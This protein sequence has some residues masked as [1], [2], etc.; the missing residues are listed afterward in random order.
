MVDVLVS[1]KTCPHPPVITAGGSDG[2]P[3]GGSPHTWP[4]GASVVSLFPRC[5][6]ACAGGASKRVRAGP[7]GH[8]AIRLPAEGSSG[9]SRQT[10]S[11][12]CLTISTI[13]ATTRSAHSQRR[14]HSKIDWPSILVGPAISRASVRERQP[15]SNFRSLNFLSFENRTA[16]RLAPHISRSSSRVARRA[17]RVHSSCVQAD[18]GSAP[19]IRRGRDGDDARHVQPGTVLWR[20]HFSIATFCT[21][22]PF[23]SCAV[24]TR[25]T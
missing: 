13:I 6:I 8:P 4:L 10:G 12:R 7:Y 11:D 24:S 21:S 25:A 16:S 3:A 5:S 1:P 17:S 22:R 20:V 18:V 15:R 2:R 19:A 23:G 9:R 14:T